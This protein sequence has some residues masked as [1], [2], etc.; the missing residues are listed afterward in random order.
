[1]PRRIIIEMT[2]EIWLGIAL[3]ISF[4]INA[5]FVWLLREQSVKLLTVSENV[6]DLVE[7]IENFRSHLKSVYELESYYGDETLNF[8]LDHTRKLSNL[9]GVQYGDIIAITERIEYETQE[10][11]NS[12]EETIKKEQDVF[13]AGTRER[14]S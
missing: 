10:E 4:L 3:G 2:I 5:F 8:L 11:E 13:Y 1:M 7:L 12:E 14:N 6:G 9:L